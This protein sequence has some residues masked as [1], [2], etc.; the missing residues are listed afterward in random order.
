M[1]C[2][3]G[4]GGGGNHG[5]SNLRP[6]DTVRRAAHRGRDPAGLMYDGHGWPWL[7]W[8]GG[9]SQRRRPDGSS[10]A[11]NRSGLGPAGRMT[12]GGTCGGTGLTGG[13]L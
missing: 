11:A 10:L 2:G 13:A 9:A 1:S 4:T 12:G 8:P 3:G 7:P 5:G 6:L